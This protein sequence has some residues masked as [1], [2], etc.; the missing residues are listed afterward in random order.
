MEGETIS[1]THLWWTLSEGAA[2]KGA[3]GV[4]DCFVSR[5]TH[6]TLSM[7]SLSEPELSTF[8]HSKYRLRLTLR[9]MSGLS[10]GF[11]RMYCCTPDILAVRIPLL[12]FLFRL[13]FFFFSHLCDHHD[14]KPRGDGL[15]EAPQFVKNDGML[16]SESCRLAMQLLQGLGGSF[17]VFDRLFADFFLP[18]F[19]WRKLVSAVRFA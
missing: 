9:I 17:V 5:L 7:A 15:V 1:T 11:H 2:T 10:Q 18:S 3:G 13:F 16:D 14:G 19:P 4:L 6:L 8:A 12:F